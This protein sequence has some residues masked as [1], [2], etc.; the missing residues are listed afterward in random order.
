[1]S[2]IFHEN[3]QKI[4]GCYGILEFDDKKPSLKDYGVRIMV[5]YREDE[6][7][8]HCPSVATVV[9]EEDGH[10]NVP[11]RFAECP[12]A[13]SALW[14]KSTKASMHTTKE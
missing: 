10:S 12:T 2:I 14:M 5:S 8:R 3:F 4:P 9:G 11:S 7:Q 1:M 13:L 6:E